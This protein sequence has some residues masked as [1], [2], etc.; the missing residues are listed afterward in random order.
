MAPHRNLG[1]K[2]FFFRKLKPLFYQHWTWCCY[3][4]GWFL[5]LWGWFFSLCEKNWWFIFILVFYSFKVLCLVCAVSSYWAFDKHFSLN[6]TVSLQF[7]SF[8]WKISLIFPSFC[9]YDCLAIPASWMQ[10][11]LDWFLPFSVKI[12]HV[13]R[14]TQKMIWVAFFSHISKITLSSTFLDT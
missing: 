1:W 7:W 3:W 11:H 14:R 9:L 5:F 10:G 12:P 13:N 8:M 6:T 4:K 2:W